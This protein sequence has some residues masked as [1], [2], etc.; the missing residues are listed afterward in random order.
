MRHFRLFAALSLGFPTFFGSHIAR[1]QD[2]PQVANATKFSQPQD[3]PA[4]SGH[5]DGAY[6]V[7][8]FD[9]DADG[10]LD[11]LWT[12]YY[13]GRAYW[14]PNDGTGQ[15][16]PSQVATHDLGSVNS[17]AAGDLNA[18]GL[19]DIVVGSNYIQTYLNQPIQEADTVAPWSV[20][21]VDVAVASEAV[22]LLND[23]GEVVVFSCDWYGA[24]N[25]PVFPAEVIEISGHTYSFAAKLANGQVVNWGYDDCGELSDEWYANLSDFD[26]GYLLAVGLTPE[27]AIVQQGCYCEEPPSGNDF[28]SIWTGDEYSPWG[29]G[30]PGRWLGGG[31]GLSGMQ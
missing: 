27:G 30:H 18:D 24:Q 6:D 15:F 23:D 28:A 31:L 14:S 9:V 16:G 3:I 26:R 25:V 2:L 5:A 20:D 29:G 21:I 13:G 22:A 12:A 19:D 8:A 1:A 7:Q 17:L 11:L 4:L 10:D